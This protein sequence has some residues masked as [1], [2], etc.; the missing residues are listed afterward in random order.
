MGRESLSGSLSSRMMWRRS[1]CGRLVGHAG[2]DGAALVGCISLGGGDVGQTTR[3]FVRIGACA[4]ELRLMG[5]T[6]DVEVADRGRLD[7]GWGSVE[8]NA[9]R[10]SDPPWMDRMCAVPNGDWAN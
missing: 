8:R 7:G 9:S 1:E 3:C 5:V 10:A 4:G 6:R 2:D